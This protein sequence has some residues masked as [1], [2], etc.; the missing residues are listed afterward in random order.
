MDI[1]IKCFLEIL[2]HKGAGGI[3]EVSIAPDTYH[4]KVGYFDHERQAESAIAQYDSKAIVYVSLNPVKS[5]LLAR[6][7]NRLIACKNRTTDNDTLCDSWF[8]FDIDPKRPKGISS[9]QAELDA[10]LEVARALYAFL[11]NS[12]IP[13][14]SIVVAMSGNGA[15]VLVRLPDYSFTKELIDRKKALLNYIADLFSD[16]KVEIDR[17]VF[18]PSRLIGAVGVVK[19]KGDSIPERPHRRSELLLVGGEKFDPSTNQSVVPFDL[20]EL[21]QNIIPKQEEKQVKAKN[22][23]QQ[24]NS[25]KNFDIRD[26]ISLLDGYHETSRGWAYARCPSHQG[27]SDSSLFIN[28]ASGAYGCFAGCTTE[29]IREAMGLPKSARVN[30]ED[31]SSAGKAYIDR[32]EDTPV[33]TITWPAPLAN[34]AYHG[35]AGD[36]VRAIEPHTEA[37]P[38]ALLIQILIAFGNVIGRTAHF[39]AE[40]DRHYLNLFAVLVGASSKGRKGTSWGQIFRLFEGIALD[41]IPKVQSGLSSGEGLIWAVHDPIEKQEPIREKKQITGYQTVITDEGVEDKRLLAF[42][43]E[44]A[45]TLRVIGREGNTL[46]ALIRQAWDRGDLRV[47]NKNSPAQATGAHISIIAHVTRNELRRYLDT[48]EAG[49]GFANRFMWA[50]VR[51]SKSLPEGG[52]LYEVDFLPMTRSLREAIVVA[53]DT[54]EMKRDEQARGLWFDIYDELSEGKPGLLGAVISRAEAQVMRLACLFALLDCERTIRRAHLEA[55]LAIWRYCE[56]SARFIFGDALGDPIADEI[57]R[58]LRQASAGMTRTE[59][60]DLFGRHRNSREIVRALQMLL[61]QGLVYSESENTGGRPIERW[62]AVS[63]PATKATKATKDPEQ[64]EEEIPSVASVAYVAP[65]DMQNEPFIDANREVF[66]I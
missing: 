29:Q 43:A 54:G 13:P 32:D 65:A 27:S 1:N 19:C 37:D 39:V 16:E 42:E 38:V 40:A 22:P 63:I 20:Y 53:R 17:K 56:E 64:A 30:T 49:N 33:S 14:E 44:F 21:A 36:I 57:L 5:A 59:L 3:T 26:H 10:A 50:C 48:T 61:E 2:G 18:N 24:G 9:T 34:E 52:R 4:A 31:G 15:Y 66:E 41:W 45:S 55:A 28:T 47:L 60:R 7:N 62:F 8:L 6:A 12:G 35:L 58:A 23:P 11:V 51:R 25:H 46:S